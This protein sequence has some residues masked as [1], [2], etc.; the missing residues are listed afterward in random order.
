MHVVK[1]L[2][3]ILNKSAKIKYL[4]MQ[5]GDIRETHSNTKSLYDYCGYK[6]TTTI[7]KG[8]RKFVSWFHTYHK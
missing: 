8:L 4:S 5:P 1:K 7:D 6:S 3:S 2:E